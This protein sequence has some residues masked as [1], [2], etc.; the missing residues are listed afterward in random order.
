MKI[1]LPLERPSFVFVGRHDVIVVLLAGTA[2]NGGSVGKLFKGQVAVK[3]EANI[4]FV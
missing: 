4:F 3:P 2:E 1:S